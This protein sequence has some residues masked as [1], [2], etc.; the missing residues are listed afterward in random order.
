M[1]AFAGSNAIAPRQCWH[2]RAVGP[3]GGNPAKPRLNPIPARPRDANAVTPPPT[4]N[5]QGGM[6]E[7]RVTNL[8]GGALAAISGAVDASFLGVSG[9][10]P[11]PR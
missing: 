9:T 11:A 6:E 2:E 10:S 8:L 4:P 5:V 1:P 7:L 3:R